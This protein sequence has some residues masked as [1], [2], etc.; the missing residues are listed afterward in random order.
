MVQI[1]S[2]YRREA[3][4]TPWVFSQ[5]GYLVRPAIII[6]VG[7]VCPLVWMLH[8]LLSRDREGGRAT[9]QP[10]GVGPEAYLKVRRRARHPRT[11]ISAVAAG[12][13]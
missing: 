11:A 3:K 6:F 13:S 7:G 12:D 9:G 2:C 10:K 4:I 1:Q 5:D 8:E